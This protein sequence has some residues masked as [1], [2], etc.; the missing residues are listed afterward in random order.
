MPEQV[1]LVA[2]DL[3][4]LSL[5]FAILA[6]IFIPVER[7]IA[8]HPKRVFRAGIWVDIGYYFLNSLVPNLLLILPSAVLAGTVHTLLPPAYYAWVAHL[9]PALH[10]AAIVVVGEFGFYWGHRWTHEVPALW[11]FHAIHHS[12][13]QIDWLVNTR[14]HPIDM[15]FTRLC[16]LIPLH[17]LGLTQAADGAPSVTVAL[18]I[19]LSTAW[20]FLIHANIRVRLGPFENLI[21]TPAFHH[22]HHTNDDHRDRNYAAMLP[23]IDRLF[24]TFHLPRTWP[25]SY[26]VDEKV[27]AGMPRQLLLPFSRPR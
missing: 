10:L 25:T 13:E 14:A 9:P 26:G 1:R 7:L 8:L 4:R 18:F 17:I 2:I 20:G 23:W 24:G 3:V 19:V 6:L 11:R 5:W 21:A 16:G 15:V 22:W 27:P 12:A